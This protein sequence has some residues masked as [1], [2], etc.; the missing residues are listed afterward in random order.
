MISFY[1]YDNSLLLLM[2]IYFK[3][4]PVY[5]HSG[6]HS[7]HLS[8]NHLPDEDNK[9]DSET[10]LSAENTEDELNVNTSTWPLPTRRNYNI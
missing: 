6:Y 10:D 7:H 2:A 8:N 4:F 9:T 5:Y 3:I 1:F